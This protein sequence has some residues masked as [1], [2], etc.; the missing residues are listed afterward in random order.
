MKVT[1]KLSRAG[2]GYVDEKKLAVY[3]VVINSLE[4]IAALGLTLFLFLGQKWDGVLGRTTVVFLS[5]VVVLGAVVD[6]R[7][8]ART[9]RIRADNDSLGETVEAM[10]EQNRALRV[11]RHDFL[12][13]LQ[14]VYSLME[15]EEYP[16]AMKYISQVYGDIRRV[17]SGLK[18][19]SAPVNALLTAKAGECAEKGIQFDLE[20]NARWEHLPIQDWEICR[21]LSNLIDNAA[22]ALK[23]TRHPKIRVQLG[24]TLEQFSFSVR[25]NGPRIEKEHLQTIFEA[26]FSLKGNGRGMGLYIT[27]QTLREAGG[28]ITVESSDRWTVFSGF[29]PRHPRTENGENG[30]G[31]SE[32]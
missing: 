16:E 11:Q 19:A 6:I 15:M 29:L 28:D 18:T 17:S 32:A 14:V 9:L 1:R 31:K 7:S 10:T 8:A 3:A 22:E 25:N 23:N 2:T 26:G 13:H 27:R 12:N 20:V 30:K 21:C 5:L 24:E 4:I